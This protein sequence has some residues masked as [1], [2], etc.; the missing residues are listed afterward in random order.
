MDLMPFIKRGKSEEKT[1]SRKERVAEK[2]NPG[3]EKKE[4]VH[5]SKKRR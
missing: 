2:K 5:K 1:E 3:L 4:K